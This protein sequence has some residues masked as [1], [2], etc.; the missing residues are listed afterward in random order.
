[1]RVKARLFSFPEWNQGGS[2]ARLQRIK[3]IYNLP[4]KKIVQSTEVLI[5]QIRKPTASINVLFQKR[6]KS[7]SSARLQGFE[8]VYNIRFF[9]LFLEKADNFLRDGF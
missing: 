7:G 4:E 9:L 6:T 1:L 5:T 2:T 8:I 3:V